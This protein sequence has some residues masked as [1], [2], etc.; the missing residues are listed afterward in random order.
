M[1]QLNME[2]VYSLLPKLKGIKCQNE[3][4][5]G[6]PQSL[7]F[8][9]LVSIVLAKMAQSF[10]EFLTGIKIKFIPYTYW[11]DG[12]VHIIWSEC[13]TKYPS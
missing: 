2:Q 3:L 9:I 1:C 6:S 11:I 4:W 8:K 12:G 13:I 5:Y 7:Q 10:S